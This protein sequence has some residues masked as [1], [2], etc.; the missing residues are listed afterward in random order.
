MTNIYESLDDNYI[1]FESAIIS[2]IID[3]NNKLWVNANEVTIALGYS[4]TKQS[5]KKHVSKDD[6]IKLE[7]INTDI[8]LN[9]HPHSI[10]INEGG[11][12]SLILASRLPKAKKFKKWITD[13]VLPS[14]RKYGYYKQQ[15][16]FKNELN[17]LMQKI[18]YLTKENDMIKNELKKDNYPN[19]GIVYVI[20]Y[21]ENNK[22]IY[23]IGKT[24]DLN[25]RK[26]IYDTHTLYKKPVILKFETDCPVQLETCIRSMLYNFRIKY[27]K[28]FYECEEKDIKKAFN[29][30]IE[31]FECMKSDKK[32]ITFDKT[33]NNLQERIKPLKISINELKEKIN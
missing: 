6:K 16:Q 30:C 20:N 25:A 5:I 2:T 11:L 31:S 23:R 12:Y 10:Y 4:D 22:N 15:K 24:D 14:I 9:K 18:N 28:D 21:S 19:G 27:R 8:K 29:N 13:D 1:K 17:A 7:N 3:N 26:S 32:K 33:I